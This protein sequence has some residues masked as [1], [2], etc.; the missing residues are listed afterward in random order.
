MTSEL[1]FGQRAPRRMRATGPSR[2]GVV[3]GLSVSLFAPAVRAQPK[4]TDVTIPISSTSFATASVR[5]ADL[6]GCYGRNGLNVKFPIMDTGANLTAALV[7]GSVQFI[8]GGSGEQVAAF[9]R[10][11]PIITLTN[12]YWGMSASIVLAKDVADRTGVSTSAPARDRFKALDGLLIA[13]PSP[14][15]TYTNSFKGAAEAVGAK[16]RFTYMG[17]P[18]MVSALEAGAIQGYAAGA[19]FWGSQVAR[20]KAVLWLSGP[21]GDLP[22]ENTP[23]SITAFQ[24]MRQVADANPGLMRQV[25]ASYRDF[26]DIL[27]KTPEKVR[28]VLGKLYPDVEPA[29]L[30]I[31]FNAEK[32]AWKIRPITTESMKQEIDFMRN[33]GSSLPGIEKLDPATMFFDP[34]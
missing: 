11:Q 7:S 13:G 1:Q 12:V 3:A 20:G 22:S 18:A 4:L 34:K 27:E 32:D 5:A 26:S 16:I 15:S 17:Q 23:A 21:K 10:G 9:V 24:T 25:I 33:S 28:E 8:L 14:T 31:L 30:D 29:T 2:R 6:L 19:P